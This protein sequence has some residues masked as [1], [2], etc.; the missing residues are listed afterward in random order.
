[1]DMDLFKALIDATPFIQEIHPQTRG[2]PLLYPHFVEALQYCKDRG[3]TVRFY[4]NGSLMNRKMAVDVLNTRVDEIRFSIDDCVPDRY[5][6][7]RPG[8]DFYTVI[9][10]LRRIITLRDASNSPTRIVVRATL[11][12]VNKRFQK[13]IE[14]F[15]SFADNFCFVKEINFP[16]S[17]QIIEKP[18]CLNQSSLFCPDPFR[19]VSI[20]WNG[21]PVLCCNDWYDNYPTGKILGK[22]VTP[23]DIM[24]VFHLTKSIGQEMLNGVIPVL[25][26]DCR[27][28]GTES[29]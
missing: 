15:F 26:V 13:D 3:R 18:F 8:P 28:R 20:R 5:F 10:N 11:T 16:S 23:N 1:M 22:S 19:V 9:R 27:N 29:C 14:K 2:E 12:N 17:A 4:T 24:S 6:I 7:S 25:C 21:K